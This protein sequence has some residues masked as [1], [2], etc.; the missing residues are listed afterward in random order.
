MSKPIEV[1]VYSFDD[2]VLQSD[3]P[4]LVDFWATWCKPC[5]MVAP[6]LDE[7]AEEYDGQVTFTKVDLDQ[8]QKIAAN[9]WIMSIPALIIFKGGEPVANVVGARPKTELKKLVESVLA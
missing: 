8:N 5:L 2:V 6:I 3:K 4:V 9:Y 7:L 1:D